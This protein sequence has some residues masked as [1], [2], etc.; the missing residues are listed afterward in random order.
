MLHLISYLVSAL[1]IKIFLITF[2]NRISFQIS[3]ISSANASS[4]LFFFKMLNLSF[5]LPLAETE[6]SQQS[7]KKSI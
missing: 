3:R 2:K 4:H 6:C 7:F 1:W 5:G